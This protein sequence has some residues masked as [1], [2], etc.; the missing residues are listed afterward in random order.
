[1]VW[2]VENMEWDAEGPRMLRDSLL[3][4]YYWVGMK[5]GVRE[6]DWW[7]WDRKREWMLV[8]GPAEGEELQGGRPG[9]DA[10]GMEIEYPRG[11][12]LP[13]WMVPELARTRARVR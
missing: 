11:M 12:M 9:D 7:D 5:W 13:E 2:M 10:T 6:A 4:E 1:M 8:G 3:E